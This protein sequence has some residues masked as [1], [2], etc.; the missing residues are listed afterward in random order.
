MLI[1]NNLPNILSVLRAFLGFIVLYFVS[2]NN[3][4]LAFIVF[5]VAATSDYCDGYLARKQK[6][7]STFGKIIDPIAD[8]ILILMTLLGFTLK[9]IIFPVF[10]I[11]I[12][13][14]EI[15]ITLL[16][17]YLLKR[18]TVIAAKDAGKI[19]TVLQITTIIIIFASRI[20][21]DFYP[22]FIKYETLLRNSINFLM[23]ILLVVTLTS[24]ISYFKDIKRIIISE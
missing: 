12:A 5:A 22:V 23:L 20:L 3:Y 10:I 7:V 4:T 11:I 13:L 2:N 9:G 19:K 8:K 17:L 16:R 14:R 15:V 21:S 1:K 6:S 24:M 18:N